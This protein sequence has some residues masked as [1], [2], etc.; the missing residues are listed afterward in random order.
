MAENAQP[1]V[2]TAKDLLRALEQR[3]RRVAKMAKR[4]RDEI[5]R[6]RS[7]SILRRLIGPIAT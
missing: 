5:R 6:R 3:E 1:K 4:E 7:R 2:R